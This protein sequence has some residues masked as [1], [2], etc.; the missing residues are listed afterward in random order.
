MITSP[1]SVVPRYRNR[2][3]FTLL[4]VTIVLLMLVGLLAMAWPR[5]SSVARRTELRGA[6]MT[7][8][9][10]LSEARQQAVQRGREIHFIYNPESSRFQLSEVRV[11]QGIEGRIEGRIDRRAP[12]ATGTALATG[13]LPEGYVFLS[14]DQL[15]ANQST[16]PGE[17]TFYPDG[18]GTNHQLQVA[19]DTREMAVLLSV[20]GL[21]GGV[22]MSQVIQREV[23]AEEL[24]SIR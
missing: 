19:F 4:E 12:E 1:M 5:M 11:S 15:D 24:E 9:L 17:I 20:R 21:T 13:S 23:A 7:I 14:Q 6:A 3:A 8:K 22:Q 18:R 16:R 10:A 2:N